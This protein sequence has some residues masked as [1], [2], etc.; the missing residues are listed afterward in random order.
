MSRIRTTFACLAALALLAAPARAERMSEQRKDA[1]HV[2]TGTVKDVSSRDSGGTWPSETY[3]YFTIALA[4]DSVEKGKGVAAGDV[5]YVHCVQ[6]TR[7]GFM[8]PG[9]RGHARV[10]GK[11]DQVR[12]FLNRRPFDHLYQPISRTRGPGAPAQPQQDSAFEVV[13]PSGLDWL[14]RDVDPNT[15]VPERPSRAVAL[16]FWWL[17]L[18]GIPLGVPLAWLLGRLRRR[19]KA[20]ADRDLALS[21]RPG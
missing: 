10:P 7:Q 18:L 17:V 13:Y 16:D 11:G 12:A 21:S 8:A 19:N 6:R 20:P 9:L 5:V 2:I 1:T 15:F 14:N 3:T 4:V